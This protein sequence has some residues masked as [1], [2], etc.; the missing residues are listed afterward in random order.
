MKSRKLKIEATS[1]AIF[2]SRNF[3]KFLFVFE[4]ILKI[5]A[6]NF[7]SSYFLS[8]SAMHLLYLLSPDSISAY[9]SLRWLAG[10]F[11]PAFYAAAF[12]RFRGLVLWSLLHFVT[13]RAFSA[14]LTTSYFLCN[15]VF[16]ADP[17][18]SFFMCCSAYVLKIG[19]LSILKRL[20]AIWSKPMVCWIAWKC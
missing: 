18:L 3:F 16:L 5:H 8:V 2:Y 15:Q 17:G 4:M 7:F 13:E 9:I 12:V 20:V 14:H 11:F 6:C 10:A 19:I 1:P